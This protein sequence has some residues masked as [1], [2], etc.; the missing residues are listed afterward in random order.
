MV[1]VP[2]T[3]AFG[4]DETGGA[5]LLHGQGGALVHGQEALVHGQGGAYPN[6]PYPGVSTFVPCL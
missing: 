5:A 4:K 6:N 3:K 2:A 1:V